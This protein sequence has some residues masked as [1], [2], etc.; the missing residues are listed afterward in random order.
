MKRRVLVDQETTLAQQCYE[1]IRD[2]IV[3]GVLKPGEKLK[4]SYFKERFGVG[5]SPVREALSRLVASGLV[6][7]EDNKGFRV[8][9]VCEADIRDIYDA[10][11]RIESM[12]IGLAIER[13]D[14]AW[15]G[16]IVAAQYRLALIEAQGIDS[17]MSVWIE[18]NYELHR[19][20]I[21]GCNSPALLALRDLLYIKF[22]RYCRMAYQLNHVLWDNHT[23]HTALVEA[24]LA[25]DANRACKLI[26]DHIYGGLEGIIAQLK[27]TGMIN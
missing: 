5:Q 15:Q 11:A 8:A 1:R 23:E 6:D 14:D 7:V 3:E 17:S 20:L 9:A 25:R 16:A 24:V 21:A 22:D 27:L 18:R 4:V 19:A 12:L 13:G 2:E 26:V 10:F